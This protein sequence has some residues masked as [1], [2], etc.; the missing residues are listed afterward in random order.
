[1]NS[2]HI[3]GV[4]F[5]CSFGGALLGIYL[6]KALPEGHLNK[7]SQDVIMLATG[8]IASMAALVLGLLVAAATS[9]YDAKKNGFNQ[10]AA[11]LVLLDRAFAR[12]GP[13]TKD[14]RI[15][16]RNMTELVLERL[17]PT[18]GTTAARLDSP[19]FTASATKLFAM[20]RNLPQGSEGQKEI[21]EQVME[22]MT[23]LGR[24]RWELSQQDEGSI[25]MPF[26][27]V[28]AFWLSVLFISFGLFSPANLTVMTALFVCAISVAGA[29][30][31]IVDLDQ[32]FDGLIR[33]SNHSLSLAL[34]QLGQ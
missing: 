32:P 6:R 1:M 30:F 24:T 21:Q 2:L 25:P 12:Y 26:L 10:I 29:I 15:A 9:E 22:I 27:V 19:E 34:Q 33:I 5:A 7:E 14:A 3:A 8:L 18:D 13:E 11:N 20:V 28:L 23:D 17:W 4:V 16:L 31:L